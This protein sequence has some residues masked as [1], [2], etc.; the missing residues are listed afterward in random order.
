MFQRMS[1]RGKTEGKKRDSAVANLCRHLRSIRSTNTIG[2]EEKAGLQ[3]LKEQL[4]GKGYQ[5]VL[6]HIVWTRS[7]Q[8]SNP[9]AIGYDPTTGTLFPIEMKSTKDLPD[10][11][12]AGTAEE[13]EKGDFLVYLAATL[14]RQKNEENAR[15][16]R[17][18]GIDKIYHAMYTLRSSFGY[19]VV[20]HGPKKDRIR[21]VY[22]VVRPSE[23]C[24]DRDI[25]ATNTFYL[26]YFVPALDTLATQG[27]KAM[28]SLRAAAT[29]PLKPGDI[30]EDSFF[31]TGSAVD[32]FQPD[33]LVKLKDWIHERGKCVNII[34]QGEKDSRIAHNYVYSPPHVTV[35]KCADLE[36]DIKD[37]VSAAV[38]RKL[39]RDVPRGLA[40]FGKPNPTSS[41]LQPKGSKKDRDGQQR[42]VCKNL[43][44]SKKGDNDS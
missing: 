11:P 42:S 39:D 12:V 24:Q 20:S 32:L 27:L 10:L 5:M 6:N 30:I 9:T 25:V 4:A 43:R 21:T 14:A 41:K 40:Q 37:L 19:L 28:L 38:Q 18:E 8:S 22:P 36:R 7:G 1:L 31:E 35:T 23:V 44:P 15:N 34:S 33:E 3:F 2:S 16:Q 26:K 13:I 17:N 29:S